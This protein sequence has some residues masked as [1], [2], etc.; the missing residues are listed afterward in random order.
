MSRAVD[1]VVVAGGGSAG[2]PGTRATAW[3]T[4]PGTEGGPLHVEL[5]VVRQKVEGG[6]GRASACSGQRPLLSL[7]TVR[8]VVGDGDAVSYTHHAADE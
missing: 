6:V 2:Y 4:A 8:S 1:K 3:V 5:E 7:S